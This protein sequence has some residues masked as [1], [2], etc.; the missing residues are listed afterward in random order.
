MPTIRLTQLAAERLSVPNSGRT[1]YW[2][3][4]LPGFGLRITAK[5]AKSSG[6]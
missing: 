2:D 6:A 3:R 4:G 1:V 5:G